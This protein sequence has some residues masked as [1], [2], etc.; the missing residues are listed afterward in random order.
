MRM[1]RHLVLAVAPVLWIASCDPFE[2]V[3]PR[4]NRPAQRH[5]GQQQTSRTSGQGENPD[6]R[7]ERDTRPVTERYPVAERTA[8][9]NQ[10]ISPYAPFNVIDVTGF[11]SGQLARDPS[12]NEIFRI[13]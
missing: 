7:P 10:V 13:P 9:P 8:N 2:L 4:P 1:T 5:S 3:E 12:N 6:P 11:N